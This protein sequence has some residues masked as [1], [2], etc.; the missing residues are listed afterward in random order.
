MLDRLQDIL[1]RI[2]GR[3]ENRNLPL[4]N[5]DG[6]SSPFAV[7]NAVEWLVRAGDSDR[8][9]LGHLLAD[10]MRKVGPHD[11]TRLYASFRSPWIKPGDVAKLERLP[12]D[13]A[14]EMIGVATLSASGYTREAALHALGRLGHPRAVPYVLLRLGDWV[15]QVRQAAVT[16][17]R[18][19]MDRGVAGELIE[20][21]YLIEHLRVVQR[22]DLSSLDAE[23]RERLQAA[24]SRTALESGLTTAR[25]A[26]RLFCFRLLDNELRHQP[27]LVERA[28]G[29]SDPVVRSWV[30]G[31]VARGELDVTDE[32]FRSLLCDKASRVSTAIIR[33]LVPE[34]VASYRAELIELSM[35]DARPVRESARF[36]LSR[37]ESIDFAATCRS[38]LESE[39]PYL[40]RP[41]WVACL[42]ETG[43][44]SDFERIVSL[45]DHPRSRVRAAAV[46]AA[47]RLDRDR[48]APMVVRMLADSSGHVRRAAVVVLA[49]A[50]STLWTSTAYDTLRS[51]SER[52]QAAALNALTARGSWD[53]VPPLL[54]ALLADSDEVRDR[55][56]QG[57]YDWHRRHGSH[58]WIKPSTECRAE[59]SRVWPEVRDRD[60]AP[61]WA[62]DQWSS[63]K[64]W[65]EDL[66][67]EVVQ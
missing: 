4:W 25:S 12:A 66:I 50:T 58:G 31:K 14:V 20:H 38:L 37:A 45:L 9:E 11:W 17:L 39:S 51:G 52:A 3:P 53:S 16:T 32:V 55:A 6:A 59:I 65:I 22:V 40:I 21:H 13:D 57:I 47:G 35:A 49:D 33:A 29:D 7:P 24:S 46:T 5:A 19:L 28:L 64:R 63:L 2:V 18:M 27:S 44:A 36:V 43:D 61:D 15:E 54:H 67:E 1:R 26:T 42:G 48:A 34:Q 8:A 23:I 41:G 56:W 10:L 60:D 30:A 62:I